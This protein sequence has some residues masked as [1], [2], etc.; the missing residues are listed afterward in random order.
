MTYQYSE[1]N[2]LENKQ[3]Y[4]MTPFEGKE[5]LTAY[6][7]TRK[8]L[9][10][11]KCNENEF[12]DI[13]DSLYKINHKEKSSD[14]TKFYSEYE[15]LSI[16]I[17]GKNNL[18][19]ED[20]TTI[21][22]FVKIF[23]VKKRIFDTYLINLERNYSDNYTN[24]RNYILFAIICLKKYEKTDNLKFLNS[25]LKLNDII[26]SASGLISDENDL[27]LFQYIIEKEL[28]FVKELQ[29]RCGVCH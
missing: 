3:K 8:I 9:M 11:Q 27:K 23:E 17:K 13:I 20:E 6:E 2:L 24:L 25:V 19:K 15:F 22:K 7:R 29:K 18:K 16:I 10:K 12:L 26:C 5:F 4:Q 21:E 1:R 28:D 14:D